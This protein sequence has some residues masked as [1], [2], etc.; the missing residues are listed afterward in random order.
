M[1]IVFSKS[2]IFISVILFSVTLIMVIFIHYENKNDIR[3]LGTEAN[4]TSQEL[5]IQSKNGNHNNLRIY[6]DKVI[7]VEGVLQKITRKDNVYT[8]FINDGNSD[9]YI[10]CEMQKKENAKI[11]NLETNDTIVIKGI[12][13]GALLDVILLNGIVLE[14]PKT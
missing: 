7:E 12:L 8:L 3:N 14:T 2:R 11:K 6:V 9:R 5:L 10:L 4:L 1:A 13:K